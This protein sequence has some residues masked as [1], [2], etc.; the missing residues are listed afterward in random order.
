MIQEVFIRKMQVEDAGTVNALTGQLGYSID[1]E[2]LKCNLEILLSD[3]NAAAFVAVFNNR[4]VGWATVA[5]VVTLET[6][7]FCEIRG[8]IVDEQLRNKQI[9]KALI[10]ITKQWCREKNR[11]RL[12]VRCNVIRKASHE[13]YLHLGFKEKKEQKIFEMDV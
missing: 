6:P 7:P 4:V 13:F 8:L 2:Q 1:V 5:E 9:G 12:R 11:E 3:N 10:E